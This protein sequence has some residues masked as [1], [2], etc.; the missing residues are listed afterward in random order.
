MEILVG[1][2]LLALSLS[3]AAILIFGGQ[4]ISIERD[5]SIRA[6]LLAK[7]GID[8][9]SSIRSQ[10][11]NLLSDGS[12]SL[13]LSGNQWQWSGSLDSQDIF[14]RKIIIS[15]AGD[16]T[17]KIESQVTWNSS[18]SRP[19]S[20]DLTTLLTNWKNAVAPPNPDDTGGSPPSGNWQ[21]PQTLGSVNLGPGES[22]TGLRVVNKIVFM[23]AQ[24]SDRSKPDF[25]VVDAT[26]G[27]SPVILSS[28]DT[29]P[30]LL[31][32]DVNGNYA[33]VG[34]SDTSK[35]LQIINI[36]N[37]SNPSLVTSV[38]LPGVSGSGAVGN[39][40]F[41][42]YSKIFV[43]TKQASGPEFFIIDVSNS[44]SPQVL[45]S[46]NIGADVNNIYVYGNIA[47]LATSND[48]KEV[49]VFDVSNPASIKEIGSFNA[50]AGDDGASLWL[51]GGNTLYLGRSSGSND[52]VIVDVTTLALPAQ[53]SSSN[54]SGTSINGI[55]VYGG[56]AFLAT[57]DSNKEFQIW[58][59]ANPA[60]PTLYS[61]FNFPQVATGIDYENN[62][63][64]VSVR[65]NDGLRIVTSQ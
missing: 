37:K 9:V 5:N 20:V 45:G 28:L 27:S 25:F 14:T 42:G 60:N 56:L 22:A 54:L 48:S 23:T 30:G 10:N 17:K 46:Y 63:V 58:N 57:S 40:V 53:L 61:S 39:T 13:I 64:Y 8:A 21:N 49:D 35:Q 44:A 1:M 65:S 19:Q 59:V 29:G 52:F 26:N 24:A 4:N 33:Y 31:S 18:S 11:W 38:N 50:I 2:A 7:E 34:N 47:Y 51:S 16:N 41:Y 12:H 36:S 32:I 43:G 3:F 15:D 55:R 6:R 62:I